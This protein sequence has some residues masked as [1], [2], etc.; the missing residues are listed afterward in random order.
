MK[1]VCFLIV[2]LAGIF[3]VQ[4]VAA[5]ASNNTTETWVIDYYGATTI[6]PAG[7]QNVTINIGPNFCFGGVSVRNLTSCGFPNIT[8]GTFA[9]PCSI[10]TASI[11]FTATVLATSF[12][13][14]SSPPVYG[15][16]VI[17]FN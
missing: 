6:V 8:P 16:P 15:N 12:I 7:A 13:C 14:A 1:N 5:Q 2:F 10:P 17:A 3:S 9:V 11:T 4:D